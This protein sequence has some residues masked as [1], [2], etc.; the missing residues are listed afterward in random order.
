M[1]ILV[2]CHHAIGDVV[3]T[4]PALNNL[5]KLYPDA[6]IHYLGGMKAEIPLILNTK[7]V[8]KVHIYNVKEQNIW[9]LVK[10]ILMLRRERFDMGIA[11]VE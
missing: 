3:M 8:E 11:F 10:L 7:N 5:R 1:R 4:F 9:D 6:E 2:E